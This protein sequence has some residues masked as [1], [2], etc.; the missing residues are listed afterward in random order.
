MMDVGGRA[1]GL[2]AATVAAALAAAL[3]QSGGLAATGAHVHGEV[4][5]AVAVDPGS[6]TVELS[7]PLETVLGFERA[8]RTD[9][10]RKAV[11]AMR[12]KLAGQ[13]LFVVDPA[14]GCKLA[15]ITVTAE[16]LEPGARAGEHADLE[17]RYEWTC[18][19]A[20]AAR[21]IDLGGLRDAFPRIRTIDTQIAAA[22]GQFKRRLGRSDRVL[23]WG[24]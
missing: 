8:P 23:R 2:R 21:S 13:A 4:R 9:A 15:G 1:R 19:N 10:E 20:A 11:Q 6:V 22:S 5:L 3:A 14:A 16:A 12:E 17:G 18:T 7:A 24:R